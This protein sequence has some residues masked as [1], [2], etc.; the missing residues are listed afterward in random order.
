MAWLNDRATLF[1]D[2]APRGASHTSHF[3]STLPLPRRRAAFFISRNIPFLLKHMR[4]VRYSTFQARTS[5]LD[6]SVNHLDV[7]GACRH[8]LRWHSH[9]TTSPAASRHRYHS[10][11]R[12][13]Q[14][15]TTAFQRNVNAFSRSGRQ[16]R[17]LAD[18]PSCPPSHLHL[19]P[20]LC[21]HH[22]SSMSAPSYA[23][24]AA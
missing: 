19:C 10:Q 16:D 2:A 22:P 20:P 6:S 9:V 11:G 3:I 17:D 15:R 7:L 4:L 23:Y 12:W 21:C 1:R 14:T 5:A 18:Q 8:Y 13:H 24:R